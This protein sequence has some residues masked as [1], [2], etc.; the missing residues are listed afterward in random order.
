M[1]TTTANANRQVEAYDI[2]WMTRHTQ[3][4]YSDSG[5]LGAKMFATKLVSAER[6]DKLL[7]IV[8]K[9]TPILNN[10]LQTPV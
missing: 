7:S 10:E 2:C 8:L 1:S 5:V 9:D 4:V 3:V 6:G